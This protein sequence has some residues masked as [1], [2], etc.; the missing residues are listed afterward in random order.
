MGLSVEDTDLAPIEATG[1]YISGAWAI[2]GEDKEEGLAAT[3]HPVGRGI[4]AIEVAA[5]IERLRFSS[6]SGEAAS[7]SPRAEVI[8]GNETEARTFGVN[9]YLNRLLKVQ[10]NFIHETI[11]DPAQGPLSSQPSFWSRV[12]RVQFSL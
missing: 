10:L 9:W 11:A 6:G 5:R 1:W 3:D 4:G 2:T 7:T 8:V 12:V